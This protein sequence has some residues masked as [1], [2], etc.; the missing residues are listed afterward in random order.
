MASMARDWQ[1]V[2][3]Q[4]HKRRVCPV[5]QRLEISTAAQLMETLWLRRGR[6]EFAAPLAMSTYDGPL[7]ALFKAFCAFGTP[8]SCE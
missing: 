5:Q 2:R 3:L 7:E 8:V 6:S 1:Q 4:I